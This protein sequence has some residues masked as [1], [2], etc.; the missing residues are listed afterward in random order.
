MKPHYR[1]YA[2]ATAQYW[3]G[4]GKL[5]TAQARLGYD[6]AW[7]SSSG[8]PSVM[9]QDRRWALN[10][11]ISEAME[12]GCTRSEITNA[13]ERAEIDVQDAGLRTLGE[14]ISTPMSA[15]T[16][17]WVSHLCCLAPQYLVL[18]RTERRSNADRKIIADDGTLVRTYQH[19]ELKPL[20]HTI[21]AEQLRTPAHAARF[22]SWCLDV[23]FPEYTHRTGKVHACQ[24]R[25]QILAGG[26][27]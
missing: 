22:I 25:V 11:A 17:G 3:R 1:Q 10:E 4:R 23:L 21:V 26:V 7:I 24:E 27:E 19:D 9:S 18:A 13:L 8:H 16:S 2:R 14:L 6:L 5:R 20:M 12:H 15:R